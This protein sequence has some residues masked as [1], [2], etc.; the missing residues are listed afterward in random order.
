M[1][2][3]L[4]IT[5]FLMSDGQLLFDFNEECNLDQWRVVNDGVMGGLSQGTLNLN[6]KG[7][8]VFA[9]QVS[10][11][12]NGGFT[13]IRHRFDQKS[14]K[15]ASQIVLRLKGD[16][17]RYQFRVKSKSNDWHSYIYYFKTS[18]EW[19]TIVVP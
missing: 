6:E 17:K 4:M 15:G 9:G 3:L 12:N 1:T 19:E 11:D 8:A 5:L 7:H 2:Y 16:G 10:L 13:S 18:G 14:I